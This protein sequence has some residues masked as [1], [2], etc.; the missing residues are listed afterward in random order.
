MAANSGPSPS[1]DILLDN[2]LLM[3]A[4]LTRCTPATAQQ[5]RLAALPGSASSSDS[6]AVLP[7]PGLRYQPG[8]SDAQLP[9]CVLME[10]CWRTDPEDYGSFPEGAD[11]DERQALQRAEH[12]TALRA[13]R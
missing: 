4:V 11:M 8:M 5:L 7:V 9:R 2:P 1:W 12:F 13:A 3:Q 10:L 6:L